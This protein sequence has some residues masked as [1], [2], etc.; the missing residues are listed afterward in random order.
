MLS[1][2]LDGVS[3]DAFAV[4]MHLLVLSAFRQIAG[5]CGGDPVTGSQCT[6]WCSVLSDYG[7]ELECAAL[8]VSMHLLV[9][10]A[11]RL[12]CARVRSRPVGRVSMHLLVLSAF[13][14]LIKE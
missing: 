7:R 2:L 4:S 14:Q 3:D 11:F 12:N 10:S 13:R 1:D 8:P 6:F 9:L 5:T